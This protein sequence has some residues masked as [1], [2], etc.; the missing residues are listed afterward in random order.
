MR[1]VK[2]PCKNTVNI[3]LL[4]LLL[5][6]LCISSSDKEIRFGIA[7]TWFCLVF[8][9]FVCFCCCCCCCHF[10]LF[11]WWLLRSHS[12][13]RTLV[14][15]WL[16]KLHFYSSTHF[17]YFDWKRSS[18]WLESWEGLLL[19]TDIST[20]CLEVIFRVKWLWGWHPHRLSKRQS[21]TTVLLRTPIT[22]MIFFNQGMLLL[23]SNHL[24]ISATVVPAIWVKFRP[25]SF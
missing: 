13:L 14:S 10:C 4:L 24:L 5:L 17:C 12:T 6:L 22:Q 15:F 3:L 16:L 8:C 7:H 19:V 11:L 9:L 18:G 2:L 20:T 21:L 1:V 23:G 25:H